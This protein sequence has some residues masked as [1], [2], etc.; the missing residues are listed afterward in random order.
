M[1][2]WRPQTQTKQATLVLA[3]GDTPTWTY[4]LN[5]NEKTFIPDLSSAT[6]EFRNAFD[7]VIGTWYGT[8]LDGVV[9]PDADSTD[10][11]AI[12]RGSTFTLTVDDVSGSPRQLLW[13]SVVRA[14]AR[15]PEHPDNSP[16]FDTVQYSY[17]F[18][19]PGFVVDPAWRIMNGHPRVYDNSGSDLPNAVAAGSLLAGDLTLFDDVSMLYYAP[20]KTDS[21]RLTFNIVQGA[22]TAGGEAWIVLNSSY[23]M[24]NS[25]A[26]YFKQWF[27][28]GDT[29]GIATGSGPVTFAT[30]S[31]VSHTVS[32][33]DNFTA[34]YNPSS[35]TYA[36]YLGTD[37][38]PIVSW[39]DV[40]N[41]VNH[42]EGERY[43]GF[44]FKSA[45][46]FPGVE[47]SDW[48]IQDSV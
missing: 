10:A 8:V 16:V 37:T 36:V 9:T 45:L 44:A 15:Y 35:N 1:G 25:A 26:I 13:G 4:Q 30:R 12:P 34:E 7:Q 32:S 17:S 24:T 28:S 48:V 2:I 41:I 31:S 5:R 27:G 23:D 46:L 21:A 20:L 11:D 40:T 42:G 43:I 38:D 39:T 33:L 47:V 19:T 3:R 6:L 14:Q 22:G 29:V 18:G